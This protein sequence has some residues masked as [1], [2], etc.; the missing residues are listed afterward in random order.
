MKFI[1]RCAE[2]REKDERKDIRDKIRGIYVLF[3]KK[4]KYYNVVYVGMARGGKTGVKSRINSHAKSKTKSKFWT[5]FS[6]FEVHDNISSAEVEE[7]EGLF[8]H[9][10]RFDE[11]ANVINIQK[12]HHKLIEVRRNQMK[13]WNTDSMI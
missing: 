12:R 1:K 7:L 2:F 11:K 4:G 8:R 13:T 10:F 6:I 3:S 9:I 5:H